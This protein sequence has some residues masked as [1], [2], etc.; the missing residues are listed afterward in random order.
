[1]YIYI[2]IHT[3]IYIH[4]YVCIYTHIYIFRTH[5]MPSQG[6]STNEELSKVVALRQRSVKASPLGV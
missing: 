4:I 3:C 2:Y 1:M 5:H 6:D